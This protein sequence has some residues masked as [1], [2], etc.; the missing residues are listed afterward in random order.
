VLRGATVSADIWA[1]LQ[2]IN[3]SGNPYSSKRQS[4]IADS[5]MRSKGECS[6]EIQSSARQYDVL[7]RA[8]S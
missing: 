7:Y 2:I 4:D 6:L 1:Y 8:L 3:M 5:K